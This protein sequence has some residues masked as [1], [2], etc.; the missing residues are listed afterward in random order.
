GDSSPVTSR[1]FR[2]ALIA[3]SAISS[4]VDLP[5]PGS[6]PTSTSDAGTRP[7]PSTRSSSG[8]PVGIRSASSASTSTR[9]SSGRAADLAAPFGSARDSSTSVPNSPQPGHLPNQRPDE[10]PH[11]GQE[12][13]D[14]AA[15]ATAPVYEPVL[16]PLCAGLGITPSRSG[17][18]PW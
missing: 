17:L 18:P 11:S 10:Y 4:S 15:L 8:T 14:A 16:M 12:K 6:P 13:T 9:R 7:P 1:T 5:T 3:R 2:S